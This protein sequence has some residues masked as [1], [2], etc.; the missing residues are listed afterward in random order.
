MKRE[1]LFAKALKVVAIELEEELLHSPDAFLEA[2]WGEIKYEMKKLAGENVE[3]AWNL[4]K[5]IERVREEVERRKIDLKKFKNE[6]GEP[7]TNLFKRIIREVAKESNI[8]LNNDALS[9]LLNFVRNQYSTAGTLTGALYPAR[10][11]YYREEFAIP[12]FYKTGDD[13]SCF[14]FGGCNEGSGEWLIN[15]DNKFDRAKFVVFHYKPHSGNKEGW[16]RCWAYKVSD[17]SIFATNF[18]SKGFEIKAQWLKYAL[19]RVL[20]SLFDLS[21]NVKFAIGK[22]IYLP[23]Y[24]NGD[25][26]IIYEKRAYQSSDE[27]VQASEKIQSECMH[28]GILVKLGDLRRFQE[29]LNHIQGAIICSDC[30]EYFSNLETCEGCEE[31]FYRDDMYYHDD[32][33][34]CENCYIERFQR[35][36]ICGEVFLRSEMRVDRDGYWLCSECALEYRRQC[37]VCGEW[38]YPD[39]VRTYEVLNVYLG[40]E[41]I[42][43]CKECEQDLIKAKCSCGREFYFS[44]RDYEREVRLRDM[45]RLGLCY[46]CFREYRRRI[47]REIFENELQLPL[48]FD[49]ISQLLI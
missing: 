5:F 25:G 42:Y 17:Q 18:Y 14:R 41:E 44:K 10:A 43:V 2:L 47:K 1:E 19:V 35:C 34:W 26:L 40:I 4:N 30:Y 28:C 29:E 9:R 7:I 6:K 49:P 23:I 36:E 12:D 39:E 32:A 27:V 24:L 11:F 3:I 46:E 13:N 33:Y 21:E 16:G 37:G 8:E 15:E 45:I 48:P 20:R 38:V 31:Q 22:N